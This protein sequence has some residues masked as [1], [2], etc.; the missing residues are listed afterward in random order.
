[1]RLGFDEYFIR[2]AMLASERAT[3]ERLRVG[4]VIV[5]DKKV[6][7]TG[8]NG[9]ASGEAHCVDEGC[10]VRDNHCIRTIHAEQNALLQ[11]AK[12]GVSV[13]GAALYATHF[14]CLHCTKSL[15]TAGIREIVWLHDYRNDEYAIHLINQA[16]VPMRQFQFTGGLYVPTNSIDRI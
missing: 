2:M 9:S 11:S 8:Y 4:A 6:L 5:K 1:M 12:Y 14:P 15:I 7:A 3:C 16:G 13:E 10:Y